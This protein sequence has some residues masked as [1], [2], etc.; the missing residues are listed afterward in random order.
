[1]E[2]AR[3]LSACL[4]PSDRL[5]GDRHA[6]PA[7]LAELDRLETVLSTVG[8]NHDRRREI[9][10]RLQGILARWQSHSGAA[11]PGEVDV[12]QVAQTATVDELLQLI[13]RELS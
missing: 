3:H 6:I 10:Q 7:G 1:V 2:L 5:P 13:D 11:S 4:L 12:V 9:T 8:D